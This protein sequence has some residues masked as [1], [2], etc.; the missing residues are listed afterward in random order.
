MSIVQ[1]GLALAL[2]MPFILAVWIW[3]VFLH[4]QPATA[5]A[6]R[7]YTLAE[8]CGADPHLVAPFVD[9]EAALRDVLVV[10]EAVA[11]S[12]WVS[13]ELAVDPAM[14]VSMDPSALRMALHDIMVTAINATLGGQVLVAAATFG[15]ELH[16]RITYDGSGADQQ[17][18]E[19]SMRRT[20][21]S[22]ALQGGSIAIEARPGRGTTVTV[23][24][25]MPASAQQEACGSMQPTMLADQAA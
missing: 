24:L 5:C 23:R 10:V 9:L 15:R 14:T 22:I 19:T 7:P 13:M 21:A 16:I 3:I 4:R 25:P 20:E 8:A 6:T 2:A 11:R 18:R 12:R 17:C 1:S